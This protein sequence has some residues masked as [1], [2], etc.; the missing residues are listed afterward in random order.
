MVGHAEGL[1][2]DGGPGGGG[3]CLC[4]GVDC[5][6]IQTQH[7][8]WKANVRTPD[9]SGLVPPQGEGAA[10][11]LAVAGDPHADEHAQRGEIP[12]FAVFLH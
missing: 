12:H 9:V 11:S 4:P 3:I 7:G 6:C 10:A 1:L 8:P 2:F 5:S